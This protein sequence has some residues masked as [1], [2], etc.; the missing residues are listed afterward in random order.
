MKFYL[1]V[2][3]QLLNFKYIKIYQILRNVFELFCIDFFINMLRIYNFLNS[4]QK[5]VEA[6]CV[7]VKIE[8]GK[9]DF[10]QYRS[11]NNQSKLYKVKTRK[12]LGI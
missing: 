2:K 8:G 11:P 9:S 1:D 5:S 10:Q 12:F 7:G 6:V 4:Q 3:Q